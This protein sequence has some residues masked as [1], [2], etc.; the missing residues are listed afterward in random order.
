MKLCFS[1]LA[2]WAHI[3]QAF[4]GQKFKA[5]GISAQ[6]QGFWGEE[7]WGQKFLGQKFRGRIILGRII[8][9]FRTQNFCDNHLVQLC[10]ERYSSRK[11]C[12]PNINSPQKSFVL[13]QILSQNFCSQ[14]PWSQ[15]ASIPKILVPK[16]PLSWKSCPMKIC[17]SESSVLK[18]GVLKSRDTNKKY[19]TRWKKN[20]YPTSFDLI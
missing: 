1:C 15:N 12:V 11:F 2:C 3:A 4:W 13:S 20:S 17:F 5:W 18:I 10:T 16:T 6:K 9:L 19:P 14:K 7:F 8:V